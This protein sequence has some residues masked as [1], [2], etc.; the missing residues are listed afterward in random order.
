MAA[1]GRAAEAAIPAEIIAT[2]AEFAE[3]LQASSFP[4]SPTLQFACGKKIPSDLQ[5]IKDMRK[6]VIDLTSAFAAAYV[7]F[8]DDDENDAVDIALVAWIT[9]KHTWNDAMGLAA[10]AAVFF[11][12]TLSEAYQ[13]IIRNS[14]Q[15][16]GRGAVINRHDWL[17]IKDNEA[18]LVAVYDP[19][20]QAGRVG[21]KALFVNEEGHQAALKA[22]PL[23]AERKNAEPFR[24]KCKDYNVSPEMLA[25]FKDLDAYRK[26]ARLAV[27]FEG[28]GFEHRAYIIER[29]GVIYEAALKRAAKARRLVGPFHAHAVAA[30]GVSGNAASLEKT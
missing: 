21:V 2:A 23:F 1:A 13:V 10:Y 22:L 28:T 11:R 16:Y 14:G 20:L 5:K 17:V 3:L 27:T 4:V 7:D 29:A 18:K 8:D 15:S 12:A 9:K 30:A 25:F 6:S 24:R 26:L 19:W